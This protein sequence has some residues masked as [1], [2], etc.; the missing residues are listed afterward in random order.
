MSQCWHRDNR[1]WIRQHECTGIQFQCFYGNRRNFCCLPFVRFPID[2]ADQLDGTQALFTL[3][4]PP[5][6]LCLHYFLSALFWLCFKPGL[7][8]SSGFGLRIT[9]TGL[10]RSFYCSRRRLRLRLPKTRASVVNN[11]LSCLDVAL[12]KLP[13]RIDAA[14]GQG[15][16]GVEFSTSTVVG[17]LRIGDEKAPNRIARVAISV[18]AG[19]PPIQI[20]RL[21]NLEVLRQRL[22]A[23]RIDDAGFA[24]VLREASTGLSISPHTVAVIPK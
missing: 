8:A 15:L 12:E 10:T 2:L 16:V 19:E 9:R 20:P 13:V 3:S 18:K 1:S 7:I 14:M 6:A 23:Q 24:V 21:A 17:F 5:L 11:P 22:V 4:Q